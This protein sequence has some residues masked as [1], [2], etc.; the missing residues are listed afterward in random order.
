MLK[1]LGERYSA[2]VTIPAEPRV[3]N[4]VDENLRYLESCVDSGYLFCPPFKQ[5]VYNYK[6][7]EFVEKTFYVL[8]L[9]KQVVE[10]SPTSNLD[11]PPSTPG[12]TNLQ[13]FASGM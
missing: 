6:S 13:R 8:K 9:P 1:G 7:S 2:V 12:A 3:V 10:S 11:S 4:G 5:L